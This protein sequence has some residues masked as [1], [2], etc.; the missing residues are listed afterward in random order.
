MNVNRQLID[1]KKWRPQEELYIALSELD[2]SW[3]P[4]E[5]EKIKKLWAYG[6]HIAKIAEMLE[7]DIDE[8]AV[9]IMDLARKN[10]IRRRKNGVLGE[11]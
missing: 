8:V 4:G 5:V 11:V 3:F 1:I 2:F 6:L 7:R 9:L 10:K